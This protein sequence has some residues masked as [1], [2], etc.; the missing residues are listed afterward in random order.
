MIAMQPNKLGKYIATRRTSLRLT[1]EEVVER[2][3]EYGV[4]RAATTLANW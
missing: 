3:R 4:D 2:L 1:Q